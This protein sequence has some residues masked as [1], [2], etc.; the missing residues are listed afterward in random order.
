[1]SLIS[2]FVGAFANRDITPIEIG[3]VANHP[4]YSLFKT[5]NSMYDVSFTSPNDFY[6]KFNQYIVNTIRVRDEEREFEQNMN[7]FGH[8]NEEEFGRAISKGCYA[9]RN[10]SYH[11][12]FRT[13][14][15]CTNFVPSSDAGDLPDSVDWRNNDAVTP[16]KDQGQCGSCWSFSATGAMEGAWA[17]TQNELLSLSEQQLVDCSKSYGDHGCYGGLMDSAFQYAIDNGMCTEDEDPYEAK[18]E[19][20]TACDVQAKFSS[21]IDVTPNN[22]L[23]LKEAV[24]RGPVSI[25][26]EADTTVFQLYSSGVITDESCGTSL[27]HGVL[28][29]GYGEEDGQMYWLVKNSWG[30]SWGDDGYVKIARSDSTND[31]GIC[32]IAMQP[33]Y[34]VV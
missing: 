12:F 8:M 6:T 15:S 33:S 25:A 31:P 14:S 17:I 7:Q 3:S 22:Q 28:V 2:V 29:V 13:R 24:S 21:C 5:H 11:D 32:G 19:T 20:C 30:P 9:H 34:P 27:D 26:I 16:V 18:S 10:S 23:H 1:M 4:L